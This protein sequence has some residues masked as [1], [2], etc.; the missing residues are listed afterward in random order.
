MSLLEGDAKNVVKGLAHTS[1]N[2]P[3]ACNL[4]K[5]RYKKPERI[6]FAHVQE[7]L[8]GHVNINVGGPRG[9]AQLWKLRDDILVHI[10][11]LET[12]GVTGKQ[13]EVFLTPIILSR[14][15]SEMRLEWARDGDGH[16]NDLEFLLN[17]LDKEISR[18]ERSA[19]SGSL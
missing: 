4:L 13:C 12:L 7:L 15:H 3:V 2:Y 6:I 11:S 14:L 1:A 9:V 8:N 5:E 18:L 16:E 17:F 10:H 19:A